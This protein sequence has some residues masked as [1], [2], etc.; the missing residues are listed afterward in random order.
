M[1]QY[2]DREKLITGC[3][4]V[5]NELFWIEDCIKSH[6]P[7]FDA[8]IVVDGSNDGTT[9]VF[10][11]YGALIIP[12]EDRPMRA[13]SFRNEMLTHVKTPWA[14]FFFADERI[15]TSMTVEEVRAFI[16][17][18]EDHDILQLRR[19]NNMGPGEPQGYQ[20]PDFQGNIVRPTVIYRGHPHEQPR[21]NSATPIAQE[22]LEITHLF[23]LSDGKKRR[24]DRWDN[25]ATRYEGGK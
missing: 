18:K 21:G 14:W 5:Y 9:K 22:P 7:Y 19:H 1:Y 25:F 3:T 12:Q 16:K 8:L 10:E 17:S 23:R 11:E 15:K 2:P 13:A 24:N 20:Y 4:F 6:I